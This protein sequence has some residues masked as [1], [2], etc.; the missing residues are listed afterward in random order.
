MIYESFLCVGINITLLF[1]KKLKLFEDPKYKYCH[2]IIPFIRP[3]KP[4]LLN[5]YSTVSSYLYHQDK[6]DSFESNPPNTKTPQELVYSI[7]NSIVSIS[8]IEPCY[9]KY[10]IPFHLCKYFGLNEVIPI[11]VDILF[12]NSKLL[13]FYIFVLVT[14]IKPFHNMNPLVTHILLMLMRY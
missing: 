14:Y 1:I 5:Y 2:K 13:I 9:Y 4:S 6:Y 11:C 7:V 10:S 8:L 3:L 12:Y